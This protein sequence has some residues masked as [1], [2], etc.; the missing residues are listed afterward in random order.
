MY[1]HPRVLG[2]CKSRGIC[3]HTG[4]SNVPRFLATGSV[5][6]DGGIREPKEIGSELF[7]RRTQILTRRALVGAYNDP[8]QIYQRQ[9]LIHTWNAP[10]VFCQASNWASSFVGFQLSSSSWPI[11]NTRVSTLPP[12]EP[13]LS[14]WSSM[15]RVGL[16]AFPRRFTICASQYLSA[17]QG[18]GVVGPPL[19][20][21]IHLGD[22]N[23][24]PPSEQNGV[25]FYCLC[26]DV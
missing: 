2:A 11:A 21:L 22:P 7:P 18:H 17:F 16:S 24:R 1:P 3:R 13:A 9:T 23:D 20:I 19:R 10:A 25:G 8:V 5:S 6:W 26:H 15:F 12:P 4:E 14:L